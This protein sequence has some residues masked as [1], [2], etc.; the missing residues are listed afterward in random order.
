MTTKL[1]HREM[2]QAIP[3]RN[4][5]RR[6]IILKIKDKSDLDYIK[7]VSKHCDYIMRVTYG[8]F[9]TRVTRAG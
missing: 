6:V 4:K 7:V 2:K 9:N 5:G 3:A 8:T 1:Q